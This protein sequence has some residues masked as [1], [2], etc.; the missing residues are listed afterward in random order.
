[1]S[2]ASPSPVDTTNNPHARLRTLPFGSVRL[3]KGFWS[4]RQTINRGAHAMRVWIPRAQ[5]SPRTDPI[6]HH[7]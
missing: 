1:M 7:G 2:A 4:R 3:N 6:P 5:A